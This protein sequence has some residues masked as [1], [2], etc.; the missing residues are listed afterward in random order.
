MRSR[1]GSTAPNAALQPALLARHPLGLDAVADAEL[2]DRLGQVV[3]HRS[4][5]EVELGG[6]V[7][8]RP[9]FAGQPKRLAIPG[10]ARVG[11]APSLESQLRL[12]G[13]DAADAFAERNHVDQPDD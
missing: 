9:A 5:R 13:A 11:L 6:N 4:V 8:G 3:A 1:F 12:D 2:A 10:V 7:A